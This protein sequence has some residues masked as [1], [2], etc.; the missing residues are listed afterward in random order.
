L[1]VFPGVD[2]N[3][4]GMLRAGVLA[5]NEAPLHRQILIDGFT[6]S[7]KTAAPMFPLYENPSDWDEYGEVIN[8]DDYVVKETEFTT[9]LFPIYLAVLSYNLIYRSIRLIGFNM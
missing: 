2:I 7:D 8:P 9:G 6:A 1:Y 3:F 4:Y 5:T